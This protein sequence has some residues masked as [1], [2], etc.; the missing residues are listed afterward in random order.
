MQQARKDEITVRKQ[1]ERKNPQIKSTTNAGNAKYEKSH[2][3]PEKV[4]NQPGSPTTSAKRSKR[5]KNKK[6][7]VNGVFELS[8]SSRSV[9]QPSSPSRS[10]W[11]PS[12]PSRSVWQPSDPSRLVWQPSVVSPTTPKRSFA[13]TASSTPPKEVISQ[14]YAE[15]LQVDEYV[16]VWGRKGENCIGR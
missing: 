8:S 16:S 7:N 11:Q 14:Q 2:P 1:L 9:W 15:D 13:D 10:V 5:K 3:I 6:K 4:V 12:S